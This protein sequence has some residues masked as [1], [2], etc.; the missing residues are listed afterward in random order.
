MNS[1]ALQ[2]LGPPWPRLAIDVLQVEAAPVELTLD[3]LG[4]LRRVGGDV[5]IARRYRDLLDLDAVEEIGG[6]LTVVLGDRLPRCFGGLR[7]QGAAQIDAA[8][9]G[10]LGLPSLQ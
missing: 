2:I 9:V 10:P 6:V 4:G 7:A 8:L 5:A 1:P 3:P